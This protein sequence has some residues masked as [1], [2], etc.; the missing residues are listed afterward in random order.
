[1][2]GMD[3]DN[4][5]T[6]EKLERTV[7][8]DLGDRTS[9]YCILDE[10]GE[11]VG[12]GEVK[13]SKEEFARLF[14]GMPR[15]RVVMEVGTHSPWASEHLKTWHEVVVADAQGVRALLKGR[16]KNDRA[17]AEG[18]ARLGRSDLALLRAVHHRSS[19]VQQDRAVLELREG[20]VEARKK[21]VNQLRGICKSLGYRLEAK[22]YRTLTS[23]IEALPAQLQA[24]AKPTMEAIKSISASVK[25]LDGE[26]ERLGQERYPV[27]AL[28]RRV[29]GVGPIIA[30]AYAVTIEDPD[31]FRRSR[32]VGAY[33]GLVPGQR[34]SGKQQPQLRISKAGDKMLRRL[35]VQG[36]HYIVGRGPD[37]DLKRWAAPRMELGGKHGKKRTIVAVARKLAVLLHHLWATGEVY[38]PLYQATRRQG[39]AAA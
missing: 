36:A 6:K 14:E 10:E 29:V 20:L 22:S 31:R 24:L 26:V 30:L 32:D 33:L 39:Q 12:R 4:A 1:M 18:L 23:S 16:R 28:L 21:L 13:T 25:Q 17:D 8:L 35:L 15:S 3:K 37:S 27:T 38:E 34:D 9:H 5:M 2:T 11:I 7:G 19:Q